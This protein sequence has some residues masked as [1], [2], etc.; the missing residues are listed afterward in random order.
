MITFPTLN[1]R[2]ENLLIN[3][4]LFLISLAIM[5]GLLEVGVRV[6]HLQSDSVHGY[7][8]C[9]GTKGIPNK[10][11]YRV[12]PDYKTHLKMNK[13]GYRDIDHEIEKDAGGYR[14]LILGDSFTEGYTVPLEDTIHRRLQKLFSDQD[15]PV[16]VISL[17]MNGYSTAQSLLALE[18]YGLV[19]NP[20]LVIYNFY[21][22]DVSDNYFRNNDFL[23][24]FN[25]EQGKL[26]LDTTYID[27]REKRRRGEEDVSLVK[28][29]LNLIRAHSF[30]VRFINYKL[31]H[32]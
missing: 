11:G 21:I 32:T 6:F 2:M 10:S 31:L 30:A 25:L 13:I 15:Y 27:N 1:E 7:D 12:H 20:D 17:G 4:S 28:K 8:T 29:G 9:V 23:P 19:Y 18:C 3:S 26:I 5:V 16:E 22:N 14:I 24:S